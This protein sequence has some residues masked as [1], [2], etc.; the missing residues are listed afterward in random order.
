MGYLPKHLKVRRYQW[1]VKIIAH[2]LL[3][4]A[5]I[6]ASHLT[7][8]DYAGFKMTT[9]QYQIVYPDGKLSRRYSSRGAAASYWLL[10]YLV[11]NDMVPRHHASR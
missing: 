4:G 5:N 6:E 9:K 2:A 11:A 8:F 1:N 7:H 3:A 10:W